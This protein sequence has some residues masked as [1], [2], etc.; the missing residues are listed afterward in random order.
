MW[1]R[2]WF[3]ESVRCVGRFTRGARFRNRVW[4]GIQRLTCGE[5]GLLIHARYFPKDPPARIFVCVP[6]WPGPFEIEIDRVATR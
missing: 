4:V 1:L 2:A 3:D 5:R 6:A